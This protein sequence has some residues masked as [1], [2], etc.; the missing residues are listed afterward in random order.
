MNQDVKALEEA[1]QAGPTPGEWV[2]SY[3]RYP[4]ADT[5]DYDSFEQ[6]TA[7]AGLEQSVILEI[8]GDDDR[9]EPNAR[10]IAAANPDRIRRLL[11][12]IA[13]LERASKEGWR[14]AKECD[15][16]RQEAERRA[17]VASLGCRTYTTR[18][19]ESVAG[20]ALRQ[21]KDEGRWREIVALNA[22][23]FPDQRACDYYPV[24]TRILLPPLLD[25]QEVAN[26]K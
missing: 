15:E 8:H 13:D 16:A 4:I 19:G 17:A 25:E 10:F 20:I 12:Y 14:Y 7:H 9:D 26:G 24:G 6:V 11:D 18:P 23:R 2:R 3:R 5:G 1:L 21:L 22:D